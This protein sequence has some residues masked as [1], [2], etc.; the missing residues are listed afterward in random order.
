[1]TPPTRAAA[2]TEPT[3]GLSPKERR[4]ARERARR[5][6]QAAE[7]ARIAAAR[8]PEGPITPPGTPEASTAAVEAPRA[9]GALVRTDEERARDAA[10]ALRGV[11]LPAVALLASLFGYRL[12]LEDFTEA[13]AAEDARAWVPILAR[14]RWLDVAV[15]WASAPARL[16]ARVRE[17]AR[18]VEP[19]PAAEERAK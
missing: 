5:E 16:L 7:R 9:P 17:L 4:A 10:I 13:K 8:A 6:V 2:Q 1:M 11:L 3:A 14:Y 12:A 15:T 19:K 18:K